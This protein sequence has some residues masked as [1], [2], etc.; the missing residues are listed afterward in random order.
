MMSVYEKGPTIGKN[1]DGKTEVIKSEPKMK[2]TEKAKAGKPENGGESDVV[3]S[4]VEV[5]HASE[6]R[7][8]HSAHEMEHD[9]HKGGDK[10]EMHARHEGAWKELHARHEKELGGSK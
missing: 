8:L 1:K 9:M 7:T 2:S 4:P 5:R 10:A 3:N 6:R